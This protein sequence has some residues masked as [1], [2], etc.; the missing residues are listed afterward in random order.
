[1]LS[2]SLSGEESSEATMIEK[3]FKQNYYYYYYYK[4]VQAKYVQRYRD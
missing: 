2:E 4:T 1:M 3:A